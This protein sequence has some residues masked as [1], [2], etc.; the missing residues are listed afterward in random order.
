MIVEA[1]IA[2]AALAAAP[3]AGP[4]PAPQGERIFAIVDQ[5]AG[6]D[7]EEGA[8]FDLHATRLRLLV[9]PGAERVTYW[10]IMRASVERGFGL[11]VRFDAAAGRLGEG[12]DH[13]VYPLCSIGFVTGARFGDEARNCPPRPSGAPEPERL[14]ALGLAQVQEHP[15][16]ARRT[17]AAALAATF[18]LSPAALALAHRARGEAAESLSAELEPSDPAHDPLMADALA[19][20]RRVAALRPDDA[21][22]LLAVARPL[23]ALGGYSE[24]QEIYLVL[25]RR[26][27][28]RALDVAVRIGALYRQQGDYSR[29]LRVLDDYARTGDTDG[30][31]FRYHR[32][33]TL[34]RLG[35][36]E[37]ALADIDAGMA[38]QRDYSSAYELRSCVRGRLGQLEGALEDQER[39]LERLEGAFAQPS[40]AMRT[41]IERS[42]SAVD[43][44]RRAVV[45]GQRGP[46]GIA[47]TAGWERWE[48]PRPRSALLPADARPAD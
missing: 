20:Y 11:R 25:G 29:A 26:W 21:D 32:A 44:L 43:A 24:A 30:M 3:A 6:A 19:D 13:V 15:E 2:G 34:M 38:T 40:A 31:K 12:G 48:T 8:W 10:D 1:L 36:Y 27:P 23:L 46:S 14:L 28:D 33:W 45:A 7:T 35:R 9:P 42:R 5:L 41:Q 47:C 39:A 17:L 4:T 18:E 16:A 22:D 37:E